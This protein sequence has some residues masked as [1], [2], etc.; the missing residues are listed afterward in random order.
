[1]DNGELELTCVPAEDSSVVEKC[2][3]IPDRMI[4]TAMEVVI[5]AIKGKAFENSFDGNMNDARYMIQFPGY[6]QELLSEGDFLTRLSKLM[7]TIPKENAEKNPIQLVLQIL[8]ETADKF[9]LLDEEAKVA[10]YDKKDTSAYRQKLKERAQLLIALPTRLS[11]ILNAVDQEKKQY[12]TS[13][14]EWFAMSAQNALNRK[15]KLTFALSS[16][17]EYQGD[18]DKNALEELILS[19]E[20]EIAKKE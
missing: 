2:V 16:L 11:G 6:Q 17:L 14:I 13:K 20:E 8:K 5:A 15:G 3:V 12:I 19:L 10:I 4:P 7:E 1:M 18:G 9:H